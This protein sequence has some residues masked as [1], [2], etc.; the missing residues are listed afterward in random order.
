MKN[1]DISFVKEFI[2]LGTNSRKL[3]SAMDK[4]AKSPEYQDCIQSEFGMSYN[5]LF[6]AIDN[7]DKQQAAKKKDAEQWFDELFGE[8]V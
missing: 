6:V 5:D 4:I 2:I 3:S 7:F 8:T 1:L